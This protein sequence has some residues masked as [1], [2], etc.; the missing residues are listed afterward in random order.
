G[1]LSGFLPFGTWR[2]LQGIL[3]FPAL[4]AIMGALLAVFLYYYFQVFEKRLVEYLRLLTLVYIANF[5]FLLFHIPAHY[6]PFADLIGLAFAAILLVVGLT[7]NFALSRERS[8]R[9]I[10]VLFG[11]V[12][13][14]WLT[15]KVSYFLSSR[16]IQSLS[17]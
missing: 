3:L 15:E 9:V 7:E 4:T 11:M 13:L 17:D 6:F 14:I 1:M 12:V 8:L 5:I 2:V 16:D 10:G